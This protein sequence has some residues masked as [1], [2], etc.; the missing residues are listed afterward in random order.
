MNTQFCLSTECYSVALYIIEQLNEYNKGKTW[1]EQICLTSSRLVRLLY[2]CDIL[3]MLISDGKPMFEDN[4][5]A[6]PKGPSISEVYNIFDYKD[7]TMIPLSSYKEIMPTIELT[8]KNK[9]IINKILEVTQNLDDRD[10]EE[11]SKNE[12]YLKFFEPVY[13]YDIIPKTEMYNF[14][15]NKGI[16]ETLKE[17]SDNNKVKKYPNE[18]RC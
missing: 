14:Y 15:L 17:A 16:L 18:K 4:F 5:Q 6:W 12:L 11:I 3:Y 9:M 10:L 8:E 1:S 13:H 7:Y 2:F